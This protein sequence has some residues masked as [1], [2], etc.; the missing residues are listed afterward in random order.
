MIRYLVLLLL[1]I[2]VPLLLYSIA[3]D[4]IQNW[5]ENIQVILIGICAFSLADS[6]RKFS[7]FRKAKKT[8][9]DL[10]EQR[11]DNKCF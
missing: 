1:A 4:T 6:I 9:D 2:S 3:S 11:D 5:I 10:E 7:A 8:I